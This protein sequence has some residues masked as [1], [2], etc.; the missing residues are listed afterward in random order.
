MNRPLFTAIVTT[1]VFCT[2]FPA[3][4]RLFA[5]ASSDANSLYKQSGVTGGFVVLVG[6]EDTDLLTALRTGEGLMVHGLDT[7]G[8]RVAAAREQL[9]KTGKYGGVTVD[10]FDGK[11]L[12]YTDNMVNLLVVTSSV[13]PDRAEIERVLVPNGVAMIKTDGKWS[14]TVKPRSKLI[15]DWTH[16]LHDASGNAVAHD[17]VAGPPKHMQWLGSPRWSR[18]HDRMAS[19]SALVSANGRMFYI[20]DE[21]S[22][23][24]IQLPG[25]WT[26]IARDAFNGT[27]LWKRPINK[28][29][30]HLWPLKSGPTQLARRLVATNNRVYVTLGLKAPTRVLDAATGELIHELEDSGA[31]EEILHTGDKVL[32]MVNKGKWELDDYK[33]EIN[34]GDQGRVAKQYK[35]NEQPRW[36]H[37]YDAKSGKL[38]WKQETTVAPMSVSA[39]STSAYFYDGESVACLNMENGN[40]RWT[41]R[42]VGKRKSMT[43]NFGPKLVVYKDVAIFAGGDRKMT[44]WNSE[45]GKE[46]WATTHERGGYQSPEDLLVVNDLIW[47]APLTSGRDNGVWA[48]RDY[49]TGKVKVQFPPNVDTYW[50]HHRCY[51]AKATDNF[52]L[53][54]R[55]G[56][57]FVDPGKKNWMINHWVRGGCLYGILPCNG[58]VYAPPHNCACYPEAKL[59]GFN[60]LAPA[61]PNR[62]LPREVSD[63][64][65]LEKGAA[66]GQVAGEAAA[67]DDWATF[68]RD[69]ARSGYSPKPIPSDLTKNWT[70]NIGGDLTA[71]TIA[72]GKLFVADKK[73]ATV[74]AVNVS[75]GKPLWRY[76][77]GARVDSPPTYH[78]GAVLFGSADG[79]VYCLRASDGE[80]AWRFRA[81]PLDRRAMAFE[82]LE[83]LWPVHGSILVQDDVA[84]CIA[85]RSMFLD[86][87]LRFIKLDPLTGKKLGETILDENDPTTDKTLQDRIQ[88]LQMPVGLPDVLSS[89]G[90]HV[91]M[92]SQV[93]DFDGKRTEIGPH[94]GDFAG[95]GR[96]QRGETAHLFSPTGFLDDSWFHRAYWVYGRSFAGGHAGYYQAGKFA[97]AGRMMVFDDKKAFG[98]GR[99]P[100]YYKWTT[101]LEHQLFSTDKQAPESTQPAAG[102]RRGGGASMVKIEKNK[103]IDPTGKPLT[104]EAW[105]NSKRSDGVVLAH[106][107]P[108]NGY[109]LLIRAGK[110]RWGVRSAD[111]FV[112]I[113]GKDKIVGKWTHVTGV[114]HADKTMQLYI[115]GKLE[116]SAKAT[117][118]VAAEPIQSLE[119]GADDLSAVG[120]YTSPLGFTGT[121]D[122]V[123]V[124]HEALDAKT[125]AK[126]ASAKQGLVD[127]RP[128]LV[129]ANTFERGNARDVSAKRNHGQVAGAKAVKGMVGGA[130]EFSARTKG[131]GRAGGSVVKHDWDQDVPLF[132]GAM[133]K[134]GSTLFIAGAK[135]IV[136]EEETFKKLTRRDE[137]VLE[138][139]E[140][141]DAALQGK[142][143]GLLWAVNA[144]DGKRVAEYELDALPVWDGMAAANGRL[145]I[146]TKT[147]KIVCFKK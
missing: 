71:M 74:H 131:N 49:R 51:V 10:R 77:A 95:Q 120:N 42:S 62:P 22:R 118:L 59:Y 46:L 54:S 73:T 6:L 141:Q 66:F 72:A 1:L 113:A 26:L 28:W 125:I 134:A 33:P 11:H 86:G 81:A 109:A 3:S 68:R 40:S 17:K 112:T 124:Y 29:F 96:V 91:Y 127:E 27:I 34:T 122:E 84:Y 108:A 67:D 123:R 85:G 110:A 8:D 132:V 137:S 60:A 136:D 31:T 79:Y 111:E 50:F 58:L 103:S 105:I 47:S 14:K 15:D 129:L 121:I 64:G 5:D 107:G 21:G 36:L 12:P 48:G 35:W 89:D 87:G 94:S 83:S 140:Q 97:P 146:A 38:L 23:V 20:A 135:D 13:V 76:T 100:Q 101:I 44:A 19:I 25:K 37:A 78:E 52:L 41:S 61:S 82:Q 65:R 43:M 104:V 114:L 92:R 142:G 98:Y 16:Y 133:V 117:G 7:K 143:G 63:E 53:P 93:F 147:G 69:A 24:S 144:A 88:V 102:G 145:F 126:H 138:L 115:N 9:L 130:F 70:S 45:T 139:L 80:L 2:L 55:T 57:E 106:G 39:T 116:A 4:E 18:H 32:V 119:I 99:K 75:D 30:S 128:S 56:V 90:K